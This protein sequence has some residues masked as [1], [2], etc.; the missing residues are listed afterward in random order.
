MIRWK[1]LTL[2][3]STQFSMHVSP[4]HVVTTELAHPATESIPATVKWALQD[5][6]AKQVGSFIS[7][8]SILPTAGY[9]PFPCRH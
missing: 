4:V 9:K 3:L 2:P 5:H 8:N 1:Y 7:I 6:N